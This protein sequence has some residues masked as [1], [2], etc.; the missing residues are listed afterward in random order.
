MKEHQNG[1]G[2]IE[3]RESSS[4]KNSS[5]SNTP[6]LPMTMDK[7]YVLVAQLLDLIVTGGSVTYPEPLTLGDTQVIVTMAETRGL[8]VLYVDVNNEE[9]DPGNVNG[10]RLELSLRDVTE[11]ADSDPSTDSTSITSAVE[12]KSSRLKYFWKQFFSHLSFEILFIVLY[13]FL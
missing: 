9:V 4:S 12:D 6:V 1:L 10:V 7:R 13:H 2:M 11:V 5:T 8:K 3:L